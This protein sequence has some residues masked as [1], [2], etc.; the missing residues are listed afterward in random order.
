MPDEV[1]SDLTFAF[2]VLN[3]PEPNA[4]ALADG[5]IFITSGMLALAENEA[6]L[7]VVLGHEIAHVT[8]EHLLQALRQQRYGA[9]GR[10][11]SI[12]GSVGRIAGALGGDST[13]GIA[14]AAGESVGVLGGILSLKYGR[15]QEREADLI[16]VE[17]A[18][19][20][21]FDPREGAVLFERMHELFGSPSPPMAALSS[22]P[23]SDTRATGIREVISGDLNGRFTTM[24]AAG[25]LATGSGSFDRVTSGLRRDASIQ[26]ADRLDRYDLALRGLESAQKSRP[27]DPRL[28]WA[29]GRIYRQTR[30]GED[31][32]D[33]AKEFLL[34]SAEVDQRQ[35]FPAIYRDL[36]YLHATAANDF[37]AAAE[38]L[39]TYVEKYIR[40]HGSYPDDLE[41]IY[42]HLVLF[43]DAE[44]V[45]PS[46]STASVGLTVLQKPYI[47]P[48]W[49]TPDG[50]TTS[51][52]DWIRNLMG[53]GVGQAANLQANQ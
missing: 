51:D 48:V 12:L 53:S 24:Q 52:T 36:A 8:E 14:E 27:T 45:A 9:L 21:G 31:S 44:W 26:L 29:M 18:M 39:R 1:S 49:R 15:E 16:G 5:R 34:R 47:A 32:L 22:H 6:Q 46:P 38:S 11:S 42:D 23:R 4:A 28:L 2:R 17:I 35:L 33:I 43:G 41:A 40:K 3:D 50:S 20:N 25:E 37:E 13:R 7:V 19:A 30:R 10:T